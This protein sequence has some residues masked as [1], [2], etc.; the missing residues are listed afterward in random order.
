MLWTDILAPTVENCSPSFVNYTSERLLE[1]SW[2]E[3]SFSD[4]HGLNVPV[5][6]A[7]NY[8]TP[9]ATFSCGVYTV[10]YVAAKQNN[11]MQTECAFQISVY[12][13]FFSRLKRYKS[14]LW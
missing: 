14:C 3:P 7:R 9:T 12:R 4:P 13:K 2:S 8:Q 5:M 1:V 6:T 11:G 10:Q